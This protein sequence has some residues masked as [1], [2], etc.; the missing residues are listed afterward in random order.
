MLERKIVPTPKMR[1]MRLTPG[2]LVFSL[3]ALY[4]AVIYF[5]IASDSSSPPKIAPTT[6]PRIVVTPSA[7]PTPARLAAYQ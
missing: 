4:G 6:A 3:Y 1:S 2:C 7:V 5:L